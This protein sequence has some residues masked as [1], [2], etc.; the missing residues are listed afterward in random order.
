MAQETG[1]GLRYSGSRPLAMQ[2]VIRSSE[3]RVQNQQRSIEAAR[4][5]KARYHLAIILFAA[6]LVGLFVITN[7]TLFES[8]K[9]GN[10]TGGIGGIGPLLR[11]RIR[12][13]TAP[14]TTSRADVPPSR[15]PRPAR[16][17]P[18]FRRPA[19]VTNNSTPVSANEPS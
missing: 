18:T 14:K 6:M 17:G 7:I 4:V 19:N 13:R 9:E 10:D 12:A 8:F 1:F 3:Q 5:H 11:D 16:A 15:K 2:T